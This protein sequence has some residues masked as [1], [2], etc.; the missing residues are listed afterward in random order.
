MT[1]DPDQ[2]S[3]DVGG[4][5]ADERT[6]PRPV[7]SNV[8]LASGTATLDSLT[9]TVTI[10]AKKNPGRNPVWDV[11]VGV[12]GVPPKAFTVT[13]SASSGRQ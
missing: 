7:A 10:P 4:R 1:S 6:G 13:A 11:R 8:R 9:A 3:S 12:G 5:G 2:D